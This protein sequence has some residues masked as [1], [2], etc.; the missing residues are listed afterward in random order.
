MVPFI[1]TTLR[2]YSYFQPLKQPPQYTWSVFTSRQPTSR[3][4]AL[5]KL[6]LGVAPFSPWSHLCKVVPWSK[7]V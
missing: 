6:L 5:P 7:T 4:D 1:L 2:G 3:F